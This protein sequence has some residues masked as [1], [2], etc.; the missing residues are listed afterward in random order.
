[1]KIEKE[2]GKINQRK[3]KILVVFDLENIITLP[4]SDVGSIFYQRKLSM[5]NLTASQQTE[6][7][8]RSVAFRKIPT[9]IFY[10]RYSNFFRK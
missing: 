2:K 3:N 9:P 1:M 6:Y 7:V 4:K 10:K 8:D 5:Y